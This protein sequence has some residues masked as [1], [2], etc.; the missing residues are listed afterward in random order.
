MTINIGAARI[1]MRPDI[2]KAIEEGSG[3]TEMKDLW[4]IICDELAHRENAGQHRVACYKC[5]ELTKLY[6]E[7]LIGTPGEL[8][9]KLLADTNHQRGEFV[10][11]VEGE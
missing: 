4:C 8:I 1:P 10:V 6:E 2:R 5:S 7:H 3:W 11:I 9:A